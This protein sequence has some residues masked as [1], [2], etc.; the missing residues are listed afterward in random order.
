MP[1]LSVIIVTL[2]KRKSFYDRLMNMLRYQQDQLNNPEDVEF[3]TVSD[4]GGVS[5]GLKTNHGVNIARGEYAC[6]FDDDDIPTD[7]YLKKQLEVANSGCDCGEFRGLYFLNGQY[8]RPFIHS[9]KYNVW[10]QDAKAYY[11]CPNHLSAVKRHILLTFP[12]PDKYVGEDGIQSMEMQEAGVL[13]TEYP[14]NETL[15]LYFDRTK[16]NGI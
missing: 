9:I 15:Y 4:N 13:R 3:V 10:W 12:Y 11:R 1:K 14:I 7:V 6:R 5:T 8:D 2:E 16:I